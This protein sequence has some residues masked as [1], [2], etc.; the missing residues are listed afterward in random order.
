MLMDIVMVRMMYAEAEYITVKEMKQFPKC[1][2]V[3]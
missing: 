2:G 3:I 1:I